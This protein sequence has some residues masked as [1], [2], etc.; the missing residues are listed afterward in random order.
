M[1]KPVLSF[2]TTNYNCAHALEKHL[3][4][5]YSI[6]D[7]NDFEY[8]VVDNKSKDDSYRILCDFA[9]G[10][11]NMRVLSRKCSMGRGRQLAFKESVGRFIIVVDTD[12]VY[13]PIV[14]EFVDKYLE[15]YPEFAVQAK[16]FGIFPREIWESVGGRG[17]FNTGED[18]E[19]WMRIWK[20]GRMKWYPVQMGTN[21]KDPSAKDSYDFLSIRYDKFERFTRF[22]RREFDTIR[23]RKYEKLDLVN[24]WKSNAVDFGLGEPDDAFF[25][26]RPSPPFLSLPRHFVRSIWQILTS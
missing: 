10:H 20:I 6:F 17:D 12:T 23:L 24:V 15:Q 5:I 26:T 9:R 14:R 11:G 13:F 1:T 21:V 25:G 2:C 16:L 8:I 18:F 22:L 7:E 3:E 19:M 4:S